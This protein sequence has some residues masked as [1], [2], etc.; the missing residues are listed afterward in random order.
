[1]SE[2]KPQA[3]KQEQPE[4]MTEATIAA[5]SEYAKDGKRTPDQH[6]A[7]LKKYTLGRKMGKLQRAKLPIWQHSAASALH[8]WAQ[9]AH[10]AGEP[11]RL[12]EAA[13]KAALKAVDAPTHDDAGRAIVYKAS[14]LNK[15]HKAALSKY[16]A[17]D[18]KGNAKE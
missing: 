5:E 10:H 8:G 14:D 4:G 16:A 2:T 18:E 3:K 1:M 11:M 13:Y 9:H 12:T 17:F 15:P 7:R 6:M